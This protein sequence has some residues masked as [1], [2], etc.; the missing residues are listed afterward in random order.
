[1]I[2]SSDLSK[3]IDKYGWA[4]WLAGFAAAAALIGLMFGLATGF[5]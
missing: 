2:G 5:A 3:D 4:A 1:M